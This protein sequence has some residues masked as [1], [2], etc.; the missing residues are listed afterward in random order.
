VCPLADP[1]RAAPLDAGEQR[2]QGPIEIDARGRVEG[3]VGLRAWEDA[4]D[5]VRP[6]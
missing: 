2:E 5:V 4:G 3:R 6:E 1:Q